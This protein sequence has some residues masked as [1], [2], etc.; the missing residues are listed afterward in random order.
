MP[1]SSS[2]PA[3]DPMP[4]L[5]KKPTRDYQLATSL[6]HGL[7]LLRCFTL[8]EQV[9]SNAELAQRTGLSKATITRLTYTLTLLGFLRFDAVMRRYRLGSASIT[10]GYPLLVSLKVRQVARPL[11]HALATEIGG[12]VALGMRDRTQMVYLETCRARDLV[13]LQLL[14]DI[15]ARVPIPQ[16][17]IGRAWLASA[18]S[19]QADAVRQASLAVLRQRRA[20]RIGRHGARRQRWRHGLG[21]NL[22]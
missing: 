6:V 20:E 15:G 14:P 7:D 4:R 21:G 1:H 3:K 22:G 16:T 11:M 17:A 8:A 10:V 19:E 12:S 18:P 9:L 2:F 13:N 5:D